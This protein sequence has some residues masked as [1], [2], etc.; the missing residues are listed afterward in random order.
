MRVLAF[1]CLLLSA[2]QPVI[3]A[4]S[5]D[6]AAVVTSASAP[7]VAYVQIE[8]VIDDIQAGYLERAL[9]AAQ[10]A[11]A[12]IVVTHITSPGGL[13]SAL[14][15]ML[16][17]T[18]EIKD[19]PQLVAFID[20]E[21]ISAAAALA[22]SHHQ[23]F[24]TAR[25]AIGDIGVIFQKSDGTIEYAPEKIETFVRARLRTLADVR[26][27]DKALLMKMIA[28]NQILYRVKHDDTSSFVIGDDL[29]SFLDAHP[30]VDRE[31][32]VIEYRGE[33]R[34]LTLTATEAVDMGMAT[35][36]VDDLDALYAHLGVS[37]ADIIDLQPT[38][39]ER[40]ARTLAGWAPMLL[41][42]AVLFI[43]LELKTAGVGIWAVCATGC[44]IAFFVCQYYLA[45]ASHLEMVLLALGVLLLVIEVSTAIGGGI[46][47][48]SGAAMMVV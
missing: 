22:Y 24:M 36:L 32:D 35:G 29:P 31:T 42:L 18:L 47:G 11:E 37:S 1:V 5:V 38:A 48:I 14:D 21:A 16:G 3:A 10:A 20:S 33:D 34:L 46:L 27:W 4:D 19:A 39:A 44:G 41:S 23:V 8:D 15:D 28:R 45:M 30:E 6:T 25:A 7:R 13:V 26:G 2:W 40:T 12:D 43:I 17:E 9:Q